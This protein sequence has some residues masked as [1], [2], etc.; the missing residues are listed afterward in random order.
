[1]DRIRIAHISDLHFAKFSFSPFQ[2]FS[3]RWVG[4]FNHILSRK[5]KYP[6]ARLDSLLPLF[7][8]L[9]INLIVVTG[10]VSTTSLKGEFQ[11]AKAFLETFEKEGIKVISVPGNHD[12]Y[13]RGAWKKKRFY[14]TFSALEGYGCSLKD[15]GV[16]AVDL[17]DSWTLVAL[18]TA[19]ATSFTSSKGLFSE[20]QE[21]KLHTLLSSIPAKR[22]I[23]L[24]NHFPLFPTSNR[25]RF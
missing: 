20:E 24:V 2:F 23:L 16:G 25:R 14:R 22:Q 4:N 15:D 11:K 9:E 7:Q 18:D 5:W 12:H 17:N 13:T 19:L 10:D 6:N 3:K 21:E 8:E 1:M